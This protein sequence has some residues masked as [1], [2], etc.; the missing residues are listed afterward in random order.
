MA[1]AYLSYAEALNESS[2]RMSHKQEILDNLNKIRHRLVLP[3][4]ELARMRMV[5]PA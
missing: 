2:E 5:L 1:E 3:N 4:M